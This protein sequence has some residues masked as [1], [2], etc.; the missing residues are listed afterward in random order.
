MSIVMDNQIGGT[1]TAGEGTG[2]IIYTLAPD[3]FTTLDGKEVT[4]NINLYL[5]ALT[6]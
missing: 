5:F 4:G 1:Y 6:K 2:S 3:T